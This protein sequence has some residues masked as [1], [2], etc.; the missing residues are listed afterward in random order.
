MLHQ[1]QMGVIDFLLN[2]GK[3]LPRCF[4]GLVSSVALG[5]LLAKLLHQLQPFLTNRLGAPLLEKSLQE[6]EHNKVL[7]AS[8]AE[9]LVGAPPP[10]SLCSPYAL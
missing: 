5:E 3:V 10:L 7:E 8:K 9:I 2:L 6:I 1:L 4:Q